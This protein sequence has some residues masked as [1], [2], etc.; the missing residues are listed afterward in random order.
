M[1][2]IQ[3]GVVRGCKHVDPRLSWNRAKT[4]F[5]LT[6]GWRFASQLCFGTQR[7][8]T[9]NYPGSL[10]DTSRS[11]QRIKI[12]GEEEI[13]ALFYAKTCTKHACVYN[14]EKTLPQTQRV[15]VS[16]TLMF[17][18]GVTQSGVRINMTGASLLLWIAKAEILLTHYLT[19]GITIGFV[20]KNRKNPDPSATSRKLQEHVGKSSFSEEHEIL[21][22][23]WLLADTHRQI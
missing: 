1:R 22:E 20:G 4:D 23:K 14:L 12:S 19:E 7:A 6:N 16:P 21:K 10:G 18:S 15:L 11:K 3:S 13:K 2:L 17:L 5:W 9:G 8:L